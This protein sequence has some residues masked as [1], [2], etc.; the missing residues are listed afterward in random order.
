[1]QLESWLGVPLFS[2]SQRRIELTETG[3]D[4]AREATAIFAMLERATR[5]A[6]ARVRPELRITL[7]PTVAFRWLVPRITQFQKQFPSVAIQISTSLAPVD[8]EAGEA[9]IEVRAYLDPP[10]HLMATLIFDG[11]LIAVC[12]PGYLD[13]AIGLEEQLKKVP[14]LISQSRSSDWATWLAGSGIN[15]PEGCATLEFEYS[16]MAYEAAAEGGGIAIAVRSLVEDDLASG[17]LIYAHPTVV[18]DFAASGG[19][20][21]QSTISMDGSRP[22]SGGACSRPGRRGTR[23]VHK[24]ESSSRK[25]SLHP[26]DGAS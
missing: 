12:Q 19:G 8:L 1:M 26:A 15:P 5:Q 3:A 7:P 16:F 13:P 6:R 23:C 14:M 9:D 11:E 21:N 25:L 20:Q 10:D 17:R 2:R 24:F 22:H 4:Y 18:A